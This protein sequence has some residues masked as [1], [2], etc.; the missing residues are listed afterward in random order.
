MTAIAK[1]FGSALK[2]HPN[3]LD[4]ASLLRPKFLGSGRGCLTQVNNNNNNNNNN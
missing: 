2:P 1:G 4:E 3:S